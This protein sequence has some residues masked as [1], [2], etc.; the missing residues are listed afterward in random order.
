MRLRT[1]GVVLAAACAGMLFAPVFGVTA[2]L[3]P[4]GVPATAVL[5]VALLCTTP[6]LQE[7]RPVLAV[8]AGLLAVVE[9]LLWPTTVAGLPTTTTLR[10]LV[11]GGTDSWQL[12]LQSTWPARSDPALLLFVP[13]LVVLVAVLGVELLHRLRSPLPALLPSLALAGLTQL[14]ASL[15]P[16][17]ALIAALVYAA[18]AGTLLFR[19]SWPR[20][21][22]AAAVAS[23]AAVGAALLVPAGEPRFSLA[24]NQAAPLPDTGLASP[25]DELAGRLGDPFRPVFRVRGATDVDRWPVVVLDGFDGVNWVPAGRFRRLGAELAPGPAVTV[26][27]GERTA[28]IELPAGQG[29]W[30]PSQT[31]PSRA[32]G[33]TPL[34]AEHQGTLLLPESTGAVTYDLSWWQP[35]TA[36]DTLAEAAIDP[37]APGGLG[38]I[39]TMPPEVEALATTAVRGNRPSF[40]T[41]AALENWFRD[42]YKIAIGSPLPAGHGWPQLTDF[43]LTTRRGTSE[44]FAAAYVALARFLGIPARLAVGYR[45]PVQADPDGFVTVRNGDVLAWPEVAV[46]GVGWVP[47]DPTGGAAASGATSGNGLAALAERARQSLPPP[48]QLPAPPVASPPAPATSSDSGRPWLLVLLALPLVAWPLGV[49]LTWGVRSWRRR[50]RPGAGAVVG[51]WEEI[52][53]RLRAYGVTVSAGMTVRDLAAAAG[54]VTDIGTVTEI[55]RLA[56]IVDEVLWSGAAPP[57]ERIGEAWSLVRTVRRGLARSGGRRRWWA[58]IDHRGLRP[59]G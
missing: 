55:R 45:M 3:L 47:L 51:A 11:T 42:N 33:V 18:I 8:L 16:G 35:Q 27:A 38:E 50:R 39:G 13:L 1:T 17:P 57:E 54:P 6:R 22:P 21:V 20:I 30:L 49:P 34:V 46:R 10:A 28:T 4:V 19:G 44:Q 5:V 58:W 7:W 59:P 56:P 23:V 36:V 29:P 37:S 2:L 9:T 41:A 25:L 52:R 26:P 43:L 14:Y 32:E 12:V 15:A 31:W 24:R 48:D 40:A 53:D